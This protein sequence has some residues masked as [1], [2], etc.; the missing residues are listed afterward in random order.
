ME[1][2]IEELEIG[3]QDPNFWDD[4]K[5]AQDITQEAKYLKDRIDIIH[6]LFQRIDD[7]R[8]PNTNVYGRRR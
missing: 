2:R 8:H 5:S 6:N 7:V 3:M 1:R 4:M